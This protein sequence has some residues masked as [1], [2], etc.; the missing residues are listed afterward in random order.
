MSIVS[1]GPMPAAAPGADMRLAD[2][3]I[4]F[5]FDDIRRIGAR[6]DLPAD[7]EVCDFPQ[8]GNINQHTYLL[9]SSAGDYILQRINHTVFTRPTCVMAAM[10]ACIEA[11]NRALAANPDLESAGW[12]PI[13][14]VPTREGELYL[15]YE[16]PRGATVWRMME[17]IPGCRTFKSLSE[18]TD[19]AEQL[20]L[21]EEAGRGLAL[22]GR[23][24]WDMPTAGLENPLPGYRQ[25][26]T[27]YDQFLSV[28]AGTR[29]PEEAE[30]FLP[31][32]LIVRQST[33]FHF[34]VHLPDNEYHSRINDPD[35]QAFIAVARENEA[36]AMT[37]QKAMDS[38]AIRTVAVH[39]DTKLE[40]FL[41][42]RETGRARSL[43]DLDTIMPHTWLSD[44]GDMVRSL[45]NVA[46]EKEP[47]MS[48]VQVDLEIFNALARGFLG[49]AGDIPDSELAL[50]PAAVELLALELGVRFMMDY[51]RGDS[52]FLLGPN[53]PRD[54]NKI[55]GMVQL[56]LFQRLREKRDVITRLVATCRA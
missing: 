37:F 27:Y 7:F 43:V 1:A 46:G 53:D 18:A 39:G 15:A 13:S 16:E 36:F 29:T 20:A 19:R 5:T 26:R 56:T 10:I 38:G 11:Q 42:C 32:D 41:F 12:R 51:L 24:T 35:L 25:T 4:D 52:Y 40:N 48:K 3:E 47:D 14:L 28:L 45:T 50:M 44:W 22:Y 8:K 31:A 34:R 21:A 17:M 30:R 2:G 23:L 9:R 33:E 55:R 54:L 6:F 49:A